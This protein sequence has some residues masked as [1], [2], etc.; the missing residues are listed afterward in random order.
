M[1]KSKG[2]RTKRLSMVKRKQDTKTINGQK[3]IEQTD[4]QWS[5]GNRTK[6]LSMIERKKEHKDYQ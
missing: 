1:Q 3:E 4:Y 6:I 5:K 2:S